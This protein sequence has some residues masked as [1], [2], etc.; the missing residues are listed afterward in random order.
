MG[1][2]TKLEKAYDEI[3]KEYSNATPEQMQEEI[4]KMQEEIEK[5]KGI[6]AK[7]ENA[8]ADK[9]EP[10]EKGIKD[11][12]QKITN[13]MGYSKNRVQIHK[14]KDYRANLNKKLLEET[15]KKASCEKALEKATQKLEKVLKQ[16][17]DE[18][19]TMQLD[20]YQYNDLLQK[21]EDL[22]KEVK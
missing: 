18:K 17:K 22:T 11:L 1:K 5:N 15:K 10:F 19:Y 14:I 9:K 7:M 16:L 13:M 20:Q 4:K 21:K 12:E 2:V 8:P 6:L 3:D